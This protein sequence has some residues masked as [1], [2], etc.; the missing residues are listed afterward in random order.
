MTARFVID[1]S[2][3]IRLSQDNPQARYPKIWDRFEELIEKGLLRAPR[4]VRLELERGDDEL[5]NWAKT[6]FALFVDPDRAQAKCLEEI[7]R[8]FP[9]LVDPDRTSP[10]ADPWVLSLA[11]CWNSPESGHVENPWIVVTEERPR[12]V[13]STKIP[14]MCAAFGLEC[15][16]LLG[17]FSSI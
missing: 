7:L 14:D 11:L 12:G 13:G 16:N 10:F 1:A 3:L 17:L 4:E 8:K 15:I 2:S 9:T 6:R 5:A